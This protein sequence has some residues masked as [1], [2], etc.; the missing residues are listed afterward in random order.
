M[1]SN[2]LPCAGQAAPVR[3]KAFSTSTSSRQQLAVTYR[4]IEDVKPNSHRVQSVAYGY[5][6]HIG[7]T[8]SR[9]RQTEQSYCRS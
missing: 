3:G 6:A 5:S 4:A 8:K 7:R 1:P 2:H 9:A